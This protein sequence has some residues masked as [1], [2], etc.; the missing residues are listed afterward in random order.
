MGMFEK[1]FY[2]LK[3]KNQSLDLANIAAN[4]CYIIIY[5]TEKFDQNN[6]REINII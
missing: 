5:K 3:Q 1:L 4:V 2:N 6:A